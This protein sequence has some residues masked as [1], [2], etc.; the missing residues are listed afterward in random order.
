MRLVPE[1]HVRSVLWSLAL[2]AAF[3]A[4]F[5][6]SLTFGPRMRSAAPQ[7]DVIQALVVDEA[8]V[9]REM[10]RLDKQERAEVALREREEQQAR[11]AAERE[12]ERLDALKRERERQEQLARQA[13]EQRQAEIQQQ[14]ERDAAEQRAIEEAAE[15]ERQRLADLEAKRKEEERLAAEHAAEER[16]KQE[17]AEK[18]RLAEEKRKQEEAEKARLKAEADAREQARLEAELQAALAAEDERRRAE[19]SGLLDQYIRSIQSRIESNW[20]RPPTAVAGIDCIVNVT[21]IPSGDVTDVKVG[22]CNGDDT[23]VRSIELAVRKS[24][25]LPKPPVP[26]VFSRSLEIRFRPDS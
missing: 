17:E 11:E 1:K 18:Q 8:A 12:Q 15:R 4:A 20:N 10:A 13:E 25:P 26:S 22:E 3:G 23:V 21:Q 16:R 5:V 19:E 7:G 6:V 24:S 9:E 2:H 14:R